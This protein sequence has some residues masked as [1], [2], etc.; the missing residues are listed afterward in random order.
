M[1]YFWPDFAFAVFKGMVA[2]GVSIA[3]QAIAPVTVRA[4]KRFR[5]RWSAR[6]AARKAVPDTSSKD[7]G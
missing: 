2:G 7:G 3:V 1:W 4:F 6:K 5:A